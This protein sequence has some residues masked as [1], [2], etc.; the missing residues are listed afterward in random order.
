MKTIYRTSDIGEMTVI[1]SVLEASGIKCVLLD[2][3]SP[4]VR[5]VFSGGG[6]LTVADEKEEEAR[7][8]IKDYLN[9]VNLPEKAAEPKTT[10][11]R[12]PECGSR[13]FAPA[14]WSVFFGGN[15]YKCGNCGAKFKSDGKNAR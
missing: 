2:E 4:L 12:C 3:F 15:K 13:E 6:R 10:E 8:I 7:V 5:P 11:A 1:K 14:F 9:T